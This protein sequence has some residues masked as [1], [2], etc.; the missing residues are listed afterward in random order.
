MTICRTNRCHNPGSNPA[1]LLGLGLILRRILHLHSSS[2][3]PNSQASEPATD[4]SAGSAEDEAKK[5][6]EQ[7]K[8]EA[9]KELEIEQ[10]QRMV[11]V[12]PNFNAV[13]NG[14]A[15]RLTGGQKMRLSLAER[16]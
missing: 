4:S 5:K 11:G 12:I 13:M 9:E 15:V 8:E 14:K 2:T 16:H 1:R 10:K 6:K 3:P 7:D